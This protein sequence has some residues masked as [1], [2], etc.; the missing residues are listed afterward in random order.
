M[1]N[2]VLKK[3]GLF[4]GRA[5]LSKALPMFLNEYVTIKKGVT[6]RVLFDLMSIN[7][8]SKKIFNIIFNDVLCAEY[9][10][11]YTKI[12]SCGKKYYDNISISPAVDIDFD[13]NNSGIINHGLCVD[14]VKNDTK[15]AIDLDHLSKIIDVPIKLESGLLTDMRNNSDK[16]ID[17]SHI[18]IESIRLYDLL[19]AVLNEISFNGLPN[20]KDKMLKKLKRISEKAGIVIKSDKILRG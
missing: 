16:N 4:C 14:G 2:Y 19:Y 7:T 18:T 1:S 5:D 9:L 20:Q 17:S 8:K 10:K 11:Y 3:N 12:E 13:E 15:Y 6:L